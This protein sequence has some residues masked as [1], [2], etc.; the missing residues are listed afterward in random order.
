MSGPII[1]I[2]GWDGGPLRPPALAVLARATLIVGG[3][4]LLELLPLPTGVPTVPTRP[5]A[6]ALDAVAAHD[7][8]VVVLASGDP[9]LFGVTR[10]L[11]A[12]G[13]QVAV[14]PAV[15]S[16]AV[17]AARLGQA[18]DDA[19]VMS[20]HGRAPR[21]AINAARALPAVFVLTA[22]EYGPAELGRDLDGW[23]RA[24]VVGERLGHP[25]EAV[26]TCTPEEA[27]ARGW[28]DP[29]VV[30]VL[31]PARHDANRRRLE[32]NQ[33]AAP[34]GG[35]AAPESAFG[36]RDSM[37][38]K[39]E[40]RAIALARLGATLGTLVWDVG[41]GSGSVGVECA[42]M[43]AAVIAVDRDPDAAATIRR[44]AAARGVDIRVVIGP[45]PDVLAALPDPDAAFVGGGGIDVLR[46][47]AARAPAR[48]VASYAALDRVAEARRALLAAGYAVEGVQVQASRLVDLPGGSVRL[49]AA[50]PVF[51]L[52]ATRAVQP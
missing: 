45:A 12:L 32:S 18:W 19:V 47:V 14:L 25:D 31:D 22:P 29:N 28:R 48:L 35:F 49:A 3:P 30:L 11:R 42:A 37:I 40:V 23:P 6:A 26:T 9:G 44:N 8:P 46:A 39:W 2:I 1:T 10:T 17:L 15:S 38:T 34:P 41:A 5:L 16:V 52:A 20:A 33:P 43:H 27:T 21:A 4:R 36:Y 50:N 13:Y 51:L 24:L 7:G